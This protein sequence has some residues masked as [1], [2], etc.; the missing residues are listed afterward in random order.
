[1]RTR[2][3][4]FSGNVKHSVESEQRIST[5]AIS[6]VLRQ[7]S[8]KKEGQ[9]LYKYPESSESVHHSIL[10]TRTHPDIL[11]CESSPRTSLL[12]TSNVIDAVCPAQ[13]AIDG[14]G[15]GGQVLLSPCPTLVTM[16]HILVASTHDLGGEVD[17]KA[18]F[19]CCGQ[20]QRGKYIRSQQNG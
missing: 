14:A 10:S 11:Q 9:H 18:L 19:I 2:Q 1:M 8:S 12:S 16:R 15:T 17:I 6:V 5:S 20:S 3:L 4:T 13:L 7:A